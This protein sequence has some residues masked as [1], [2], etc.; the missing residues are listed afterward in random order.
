VVGGSVGEPGVLTLSLM[1]LNCS[2]TRS[3][4]VYS[5][6][7]EKKE[8]QLYGQLLLPRGKRSC[9][10]TTTFLLSFRLYLGLFHVIFNSLFV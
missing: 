2:P 8:K 5:Y 4:V 6:L 3:R 10:G 9:H 1:S 7:P